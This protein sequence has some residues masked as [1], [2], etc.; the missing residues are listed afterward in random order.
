MR[1][2][3]AL[4]VEA[5]SRV[6]KQIGCQGVGA[7]TDLCSVCMQGHCG[8]GDEDHDACG[9]LPRPVAPH[10]RDRAMRGVGPYPP[11]QEATGGEGSRR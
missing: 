8:A 11:V 6:A 7:T 1:K 2:A 10:A 3:L 5:V 9:L 4:R